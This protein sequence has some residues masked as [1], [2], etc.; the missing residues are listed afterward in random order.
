MFD[1]ISGL[2]VHV[3]VVHAV[4]VLLPLM[5]LVTIAVAVRPRWRQYA[6]A[7]A[8]IDGLVVVAAWVAK[9]SGEKLQARLQQFDPA[10]ARDHGEHGALVPYVAL[11]VFVAAV[12][13]WATERFPRI[14]PLAVVAALIAG[15][16]GVWWTYV[17]GES[18]ARAVWGDTVKNTK[19]PQ[20]G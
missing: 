2:P 15:A 3:L 10:V 7:V 19:A 8:V 17:T 11:G 9:E 13:V 6:P 12:L 20:G 5:S 16:G 1:T 4:V 14:V 18:G